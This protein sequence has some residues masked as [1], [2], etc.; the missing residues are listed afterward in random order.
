[1]RSRTNKP[2]EAKKEMETY[3]V[4]GPDGQSYH[5]YNVLWAKRQEEIAQRCAVEPVSKA[6]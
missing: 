1:M 5:F 4:E 6:V 3:G 2:V